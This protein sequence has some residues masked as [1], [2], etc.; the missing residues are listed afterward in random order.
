MGRGNGRV[1]LD[2]IAAMSIEQFVGINR[3]F[4]TGDPTRRLQSADITPLPAA[5]QPVE[6]RHRRPVVEQ[7]CVAQHH[8]VAC[9]IAYDNLELPRGGSTEEFLHPVAVGRRS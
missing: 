2:G 8:W 1:A 5:H 3:G 9:D 6:R 7:W 4:G